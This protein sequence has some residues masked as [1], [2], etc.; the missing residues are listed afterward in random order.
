MESKGIPM[1]VINWKWRVK[2]HDAMKISLDGP[3]ERGCDA[4]RKNLEWGFA[5]GNVGG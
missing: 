1:R 2:Y 3:S 4:V 5:F